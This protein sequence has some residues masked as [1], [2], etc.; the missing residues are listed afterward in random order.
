MAAGFKGATFAKARRDV[1]N[2]ISPVAAH[3]RFE[4]LPPEPGAT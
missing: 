4:A 1:R 3:P 2:P